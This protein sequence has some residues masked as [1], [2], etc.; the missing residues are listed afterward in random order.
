M[1]I[2]AGLP[3]KHRW[4]DQAQ[5][6]PALRSAP[7]GDRTGTSRARHLRSRAG[8]PHQSAQRVHR[9]GDPH[10]RGS[11]GPP[12]TRSVALPGRHPPPG[13]TSEGSTSPSTPNKAEFDATRA[14]AAPARIRRGAPLERPLRDRPGELPDQAQARRDGRELIV[15]R[16]TRPRARPQLAKAYA[17]FARGRPG[18]I[19]SVEDAKRCHEGTLEGP[20]D[21]RST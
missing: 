10:G 17:A 9:P 18:T 2:Y 7:P 5:L 1:P 11:V 19:D 4:P 15:A 14:F 6:R 16:A 13:P 20:P 3:A 21:R 8:Q 12:V